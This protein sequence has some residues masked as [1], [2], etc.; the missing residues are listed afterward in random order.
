MVEISMFGMCAVDLM[1]FAE[2]TDGSAISFSAGAVVKY[3]VGC[4]HGDRYLS[5][6]MCVWVYQSRDD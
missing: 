3:S 5:P 4:G 1:G 6:W 2:A